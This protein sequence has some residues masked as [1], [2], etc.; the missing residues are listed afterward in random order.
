MLK[1]KILESQIKKF[2]KSMKIKCPKQEGKPKALT[3]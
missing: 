2:N 1:D 3:M